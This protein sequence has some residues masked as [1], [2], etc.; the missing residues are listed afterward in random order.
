[1]PRCYYARSGSMGG[2]YTAVTRI[3]EVFERLEMYCI[4]ERSFI[5][6]Y[7]RQLVP[8]HE[9]VSAAEYIF[10]TNNIPSMYEIDRDNCHY[11]TNL[12]S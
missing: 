6:W 8:R 2:T 7:E 5:N 12:I 11:R 9:N 3:G 1:M 10:Q 4:G